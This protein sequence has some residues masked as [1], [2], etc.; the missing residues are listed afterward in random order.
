M[1]SARAEARRLGRPL[2]VIR[3][4]GTTA[5][6]RLLDGIAATAPA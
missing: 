4:L 1:W 6:A 3:R 2:L 5:F